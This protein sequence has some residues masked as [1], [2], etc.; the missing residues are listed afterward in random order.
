MRP[1]Q[2]DPEGAPR[3]QEEYYV[4][5]YVAFP[6]TAGRA[7]ST[8]SPIESF[9][10]GSL[11]ALATIWARAVGLWLADSDRFL[12]ANRDEKNFPSAEKMHPHFK[13]HR[14]HFIGR[15]LWTS[16]NDVFLGRL[17]GPV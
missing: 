13:R 8:S 1:G 4:F 9:G 6:A 17:S 2:E 7:V 10:G 5:S 11:Q 15:N 12:P 14:R 16:P 3:L